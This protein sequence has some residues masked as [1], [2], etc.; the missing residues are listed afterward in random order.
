MKRSIVIAITCSVWLS[1]AVSAAALTYELRRPLLPSTPSVVSLER[2]SPPLTTTASG[3]LEDATPN[4]LEIPVV[5]IVGRAVRPA[6][7][8]RARKPALPRDIATM[9]CAGWR[10][11]DMGSGRVQMCE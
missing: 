10:D 8:A 4:V 7:R 3:V 2:S 9:N 6:S 1:G 5:T 11:L